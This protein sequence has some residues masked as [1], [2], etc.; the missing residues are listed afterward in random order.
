MSLVAAYA[1][2]DDINHLVL[3]PGTGGPGGPPP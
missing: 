2:A 3:T 1:A